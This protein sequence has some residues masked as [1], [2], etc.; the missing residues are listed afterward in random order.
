MEI[1]LSV[2]LLLLAALI[3]DEV[4]TMRRAQRKSALENRLEFALI[5]ALIKKLSDATP[6]ESASELEIF[7]IIDGQQTRMENMNLK[8]ESR[9]Q[10]LVS[11]KTKSG[12]PAK[13]DGEVQFTVPAGLEI[14]E[15][16]GKK[17]LQA[18]DD[19]DESAPVL[20]A[21]DAD[22]DLGEGV[23]TLHFEAAINILSADAETLEI[24]FGAAEAIP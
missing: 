8:K 3:M 7:A 24:T 6:V 10:L 13:L 4:R 5:K 19:A 1:F 17:F 23:K 14:V 18:K 12:K 22:G 20:F 16:D 11:A 15:A 2:L 21:A 9:V